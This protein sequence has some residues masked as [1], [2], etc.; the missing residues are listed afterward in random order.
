MEH[1]NVFKINGDEDKANLV[2][3]D[4]LSRAI[5]NK[6]GIDLKD[7]REDANAV[8]DRFGYDDMTIDNYLSTEERQLF[9]ILE[10]IGILDT[11]KEEN[12]LYDGRTWRTHYW[13]LRKKDIFSYSKDNGIDMVRIEKKEYDPYEKF[14]EEVWKRK[15]GLNERIGNKE[16]P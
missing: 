11:K 3:L 6:T 1:S 9:Y 12:V 15:G 8:L 13:K 4:I 7:A 5:R 16:R 10:D 14:E 2:T